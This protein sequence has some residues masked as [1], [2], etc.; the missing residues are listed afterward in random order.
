MI[1]SFICSSFSFAQNRAQGRAGGGHD[2]FDKQE[3]V[4]IRERFGVFNQ[5]FSQEIDP[6]LIPSTL[7]L[8]MEFD[9]LMGEASQVRQSCFFKES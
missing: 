6:G 2:D 3:C 5:D 9:L 8:M 1:F 7:D 4:P